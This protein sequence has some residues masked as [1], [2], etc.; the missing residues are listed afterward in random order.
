MLSHIHPIHALERNAGACAESYRPIKEID[1]MHRPHKGEGWRPE[2]G[3]VENSDCVPPHQLTAN[4]CHCVCRSSLRYKHPALSPCITRRGH[5]EGCL[6]RRRYGLV[7]R[8]AAF[9]LQ[10]A[11]EYRTAQDGQPVDSAATMLPKLAV[12]IKLRFVTPALRRHLLT[13]D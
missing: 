4:R 3:C 11:L 8:C 12:A 6:S 1:R 2:E 5:W 7:D 13:D 9:Q 10:A